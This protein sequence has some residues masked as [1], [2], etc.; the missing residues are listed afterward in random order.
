LQARDCPQCGVSNP[1][2]ANFCMRC[3]TNLNAARTV[4]D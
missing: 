2:T 3:G 1:A 4:N